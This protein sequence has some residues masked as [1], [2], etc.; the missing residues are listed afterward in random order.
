VAAGITF[1]VPAI[2]LFYVEWGRG[3]PSYLA[4]AGVALAGGILGVLFMIPLRRMFIVRER[5]T[6]PYPEGVAC[7]KVLMAG[8]EGGSKARVGFVGFFIGLFYKLIADGL[9]LFPS[10][11]HLVL[12]SNK[13]AAIGGDILP[14][15]LG[16]GYIVGLR[17]GLPMVAGAA[18]GWLVIMPALG[19]YGASH[20][21]AIVYPA[22]IPI[23]RL[24]VWELWRNYVSYIGAGMVGFCG[25]LGFFQIVPP[26]LKSLWRGLAGAKPDTAADS[27]PRTDRDISGKAI[28]VGILAVIL[29]VG[30]S[31]IVPVGLLGAALIA[32]FGF[33]F[34]SVSSRIAGSIGNSNTPASGMTIAC[35]IV[36]AFLF[37]ITGNDGPP[38]MVATLLVGSVICVVCCLAGD[39]SQDLKT[40]HILGATPRS[41]QLAEMLGVAASALVVGSVMVLFHKAW[42][43]GSAELPAPQA[44]LMKLIVNGIMGGHFPRPLVLG[45]VCL[46][47]VCFLFRLP[48][49]SMAVGLYLPI[50]LSSP[51]LVGGLI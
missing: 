8:E 48:V 51:L 25:L 13:A 23:S 17:V 42:G 11:L 34:A 12:G 43:F 16:V 7:A 15:L 46:G 9:R 35:L 47:M 27:V 20:P 1:T 26:L 41:Q 32:L 14:S 3:T 31:P 38:A 19:W 10:E 36:T 18:L 33:L 30:L 44:N 37:K 29:S 40:G 24:D 5:E 45:G 39:V 2:F 22:S 21:E 28:A 50:H 6:L 4:I 49:T